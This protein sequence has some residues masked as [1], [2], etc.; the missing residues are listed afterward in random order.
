GGAHSDGVDGIDCALSNCANIPM[1]AMELDYPFFRVENYALI[2]DSGGK[3]K[4]RGGLGFEKS[5][6]ILEDGVTFATYGDRFRIAPPGLFGG[7]PGCRAE[8][9]IERDGEII[10]VGSK[11][12]LELKKG[13]LLV[14][15]TGGGG[16][17][18]DVKE[19]DAR[20]EAEDLEEGL[21]T[22]AAE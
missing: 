2:P 12:G 10:Q 15:R 18:G 21:T 1:E 11:A 16:G 4:H 19:R 5:Y 6:R 22:Q 9:L 7:G 20:L 8:N 14:M 13:D 3:G 17:Y